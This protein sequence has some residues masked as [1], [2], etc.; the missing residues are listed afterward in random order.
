MKLCDLRGLKTGDRLRQQPMVYYSILSQLP[1]FAVY[2]CVCV[3]VYHTELMG[4]LP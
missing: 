4:G 2:L 1:M 3:C